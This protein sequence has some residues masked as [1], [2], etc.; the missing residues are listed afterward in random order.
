MK[1]DAIWRT[2]RWTFDAE[3][4]ER[5]QVPILSSIIEK[6]GKTFDETYIY[7]FQGKQKQYILKFKH[8]DGVRDNPR[9]DMEKRK[10]PF[11]KKLKEFS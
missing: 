10:D 2:H 8:Y 5:E 6:F 9:V 4:C 11:Q 1:D 3:Y 7:I